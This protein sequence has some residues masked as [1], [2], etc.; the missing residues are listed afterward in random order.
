MIFAIVYTHNARPPVRLIKPVF[1]FERESPKAKNEPAENQSKNRDQGPWPETQADRWP[2]RSDALLA[3]FRPRVFRRRLFEMRGLTQGEIAD[4]FEF[5]TF[6][7]RNLGGMI[8]Q[9][10]NA[11]Q[12][13]VAKNLRPYSVIAIDSVTGF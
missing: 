8:C 4:H 1:K 2:K 5:E 3:F 9:Q 6:E 11:T 12:T 10:Q 13:Q 7:G